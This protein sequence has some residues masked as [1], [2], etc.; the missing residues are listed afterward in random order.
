MK[1]RWLVLLLCVI[2]MVFGVCFAGCNGGKIDATEEKVAITVAGATEGETLLEYMED[3]E[4][5]GKLSYTVVKGMITELNGVSN[6]TNCYWMLYT[7]DTDNADKSWGTCD[8]DGQ[9]LGSS[10]LGAEALTVKNGCVYVW[11]Y[12]K[13]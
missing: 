13:F 2:C 11:V 9:E 3:L 1:K 6:T 5:D 12:T 4:G 8:Y 10:K 7:S